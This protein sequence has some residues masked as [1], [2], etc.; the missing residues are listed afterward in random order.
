[1][2]HEVLITSGYGVGWVTRHAGT[3]E[4]KMYMLTYRPFIDRLNEGREINPEAIEQ[5]EA[6]Y[7]EKFSCQAGDLPYTGGAPNLH[8]AYVESDRVLI[9]PYDGYEICITEHDDGWITL[10]EED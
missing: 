4:Q 1:M 5:F 10:P 2:G 3:A 8:I 9:T 7:M 6:D